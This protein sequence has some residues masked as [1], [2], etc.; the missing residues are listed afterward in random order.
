MSDIVVLSSLSRYKD[1]KA[2]SQGSLV[3]FALFEPLKE[4]VTTR[5]GYRIHRV[6]ENEVGFLDILATQY[7]GDGY[8]KLWWVIAYTNAILD[9]ENEM[10]PGLPLVIPPRSA[11]LQFI[12]RQ[13][14][15]A[16]T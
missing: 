4:F 10:F 14:D 15:A 1:T 7:Y 13:G 12:S 6:K 11:V 8:E 2:Y 16:R 5:A 3:E 9:P